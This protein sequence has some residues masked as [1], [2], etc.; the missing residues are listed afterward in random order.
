MCV[1]TERRLRDY[2]KMQR[3]PMKNERKRKK[4]RSRILKRKGEEGD[5]CRKCRKK[6]K[7]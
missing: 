4:K 6:K 3:I 2:A 7:K 1:F 5:L